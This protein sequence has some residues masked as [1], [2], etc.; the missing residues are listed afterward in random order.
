MVAEIYFET[1][2]VPDAGAGQFY[3]TTI[4]FG[5][6]GG[7]AM[8]D[9]FEV[10]SGILPPGV[11]LMADREDED[12]DGFPDLEGKLTGDAR[13]LGFPRVTGSFDFEIRAVSTGALG[14]QTAQ[15]GSDQ[16][17]LAAVQEFV[18]NVA[19]GSVAIL[20]PQNV[21]VDPAVPAFPE[22]TDFVN[23]SNPQAFFSFAFQIAGGSTNNLSNV[24]IPRELELSTF[25]E[26][27]GAFAE[28]TIEALGEPSLVNFI[29]GG[30]TAL[31]A[32]SEQLQLLGFQSPRGDAKTVRPLQGIWFQDTPGSGGPAI[33][34][35]R[36]LAD[37]DGLAGGDGTLGTERPIQFSY[38]FDVDF[39]DTHPETGGKQRPKY[40]FTIA[41]YENAFFI[42]YDEDN[43]VTPL[44]FRMIAEVIDT[45]GTD[46]TGTDT[47]GDGIDD[48]KVDDTITRRDYVFQVKIPDIRIDT[49][50]LPPGQAGMDYVASVA[51]SGGVPP[52]TYILEWVDGDL[53]LMATETDDLTK[54]DFGVDIDSTPG[55]GV[56]I[57]LPRASGTAEL[58]VCVTSAVLNPISQGPNATYL[59][60]GTP[61]EYNGPHPIAPHTPGIH[62]TFQVDFADP[63]L[64][65]LL[66]NSLPTAVDGAFYDQSVSGTGGVPMLQPYPV[67]F[68]GDWDAASVERNYDWDCDYVTDSSYPH[69][70]KPGVVENQ[71][72][73]GELP[74]ALQIDGDAYSTTCGRIWGMA[75]DRGFHPVAIQQSDYYL[76]DAGDPDMPNERQTNPSNIILDVGPTKIIYARGAKASERSDGTPAGLADSGNQMSDRA[77]V[78]V[79]GDYAIV[80]GQSGLTPTI[81]SQL[82]SA[83]DFMPVLL[84]HGGEDEHVNKGDVSISGFYPPEARSGYWYKYS[85]S[86]T[87]YRTAYWYYYYNFPFQHLQQLFTW[88]QLPDQNRVF[89]WGEA[90]VKQWQTGATS[91]PYAQRYQ[92]LD[93]KGKRGIMVVD[94]A[95][96]DAWCPAIL[97]NDTTA[98]GSQFGAETCLQHG[99]SW[100]LDG[101]YWQY[102]YSYIAPYYKYTYYS[103]YQNGQ[104]VYA[105]LPQNTRT[106]RE[107]HSHGLGYY[108]YSGRANYGSGQYGGPYRQTMGRTGV[109]VAASADGTWMATAL[110][111]PTAGADAK[112]L[113]WRTDQQAIPASIISQTY[114]T[115]LTGYNLDGTTLPTTQACIVTLSDEDAVTD[116][117]AVNIDGDQ[118]NFLPDSLCFVEDGIVFLMQGQ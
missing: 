77:N 12:G 94:P 37:T 71:T 73:Y 47:N 115:G 80:L 114:V 6:A 34:S 27:I 59:P 67:D 51:A 89:L 18:L 10:Y 24:Y 42:E 61:G 14:G 97:D 7:A 91:G 70:S 56:F 4:Q 33:D 96:G 58:T 72:L 117:G 38:Y 62:R 108:L 11:T 104:Y 5:T 57:G 52:L 76:G 83:V 75:Y 65:V 8:P 40:P 48:G 49:G 112:F 41:E 107:V 29:D 88:V 87:Y 39:R 46:A 26:G 31:Q 81:M 116:F 30:I 45:N 109:S 28:D 79:A 113:L 84:A 90:D 3:N 99:S 19:Q 86:Y 53:D 36:D 54:Q 1:A 35:R 98:H 23:P 20:N 32:G 13:L 68:P 44:K 17:N 2:T 22:V 102:S 95:T 100:T 66:G 64:P 105:T 43:D 69:A 85:G 110:P 63:T 55:G 78:P 106:E 93:S 111:G 60:T 9:V 101:K 25:D 50:L 103:V 118:D 82:P 74:Q 92:Q 15:L 16:P 21:T